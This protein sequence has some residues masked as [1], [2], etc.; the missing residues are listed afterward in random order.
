MPFGPP[1]DDFVEPP[2]PM[3]GMRSLAIDLEEEDRQE[4][5]CYIAMVLQKLA[6]MNELFLGGRVSLKGK[7]D[8]R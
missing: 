7:F 6:N 4:L 1:I 2:G 3:E 8:M 5:G